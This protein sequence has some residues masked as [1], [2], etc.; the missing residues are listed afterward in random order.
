MDGWRDGDWGGK[1]RTSSM[2]SL[3]F[4]SRRHVPLATE[5]GGRR[6]IFIGGRD[7]HL[8]R[9]HSNR[10]SLGNAR[11]HHNLAR[12]SAA[13]RRAES[14]C[15][16]TRVYPSSLTTK[17]PDGMPIHRGDWPAP[18]IRPEESPGRNVFQRPFNFFINMASDTNRSSA[19]YSFSRTRHEGSF[20]VHCFARGDCRFRRQRHPRS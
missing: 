11:L 3:T 16:R 5:V 2:A 19:F 15:R 13:N 6:W 8:R 9:R 10:H 20:L 14:T 7:F 18:V 1:G 17:L 4:I 12:H